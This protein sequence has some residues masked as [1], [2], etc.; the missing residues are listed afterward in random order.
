MD[1]EC[2]ACKGNGV[3]WKYPGAPP[4]T[5]GQAIEPCTICNG[6]GRILPPFSGR[7]AVGRPRR[8]DPG[9]LYAFAH[10]FY[11]DFRRIAEGTRRWRLDRERY[12]Q[13]TKGLED[14]QFTDNEDRLRHQ[15]IVDDEIRTGRLQPSQR[16]ERLSDIEDSENWARR[17]SYRQEAADEAL[18]EI[19]VPG[20]PDVIRALLDPD[21]TQGKSV[22]FAKTPS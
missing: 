2:G 20:E 7:R 19:K 18:K 17:E 15:Q 13:F 12:E 3:V 5:P 10:Q 14:M 16:E 9:T 22:R 11:W 1:V 21:T 4:R 6:R 8:V